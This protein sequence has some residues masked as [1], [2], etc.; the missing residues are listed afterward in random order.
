MF[1]W[2]DKQIPDYYLTIYMDGYTPAQILHATKRRMYQQYMERKQE[3]S[4]EK[5]MES[6]VETALKDI[7]E[8][9]K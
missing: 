6:V 8:G 7:F 3:R 1:E 2:Y 5:D 4:I 9:W